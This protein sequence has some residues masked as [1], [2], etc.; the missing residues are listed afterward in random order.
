MN[1][2]KKSRFFINKN[3]Y[4]G[5]I[6]ENGKKRY[7]HRRVLEKKFG[8]KIFDGYVV[9]HLDGNKLNNR[10]ENLVSIPR[11]LHNKYHY[12]KKKVQEIENYFKKILGK[13]C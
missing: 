2:K 7:T 10:S 12:H 5:Y 1:N 4:K 8:N 11:K 13:K 6:D 9:H 3:G